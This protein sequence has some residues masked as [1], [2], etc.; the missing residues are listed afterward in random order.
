MDI[1]LQGELVYKELER[2]VMETVFTE[3]DQDV[4]GGLVTHDMI[5]KSR[6]LYNLL[7]LD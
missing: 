4:A 6:S 1:Q 2:G 7:D 5:R 3:R